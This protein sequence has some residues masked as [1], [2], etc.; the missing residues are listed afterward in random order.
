LNEDGGRRGSRRGSKM[1]AP[2]I[3]KLDSV[4]EYELDVAAFKA[5]K[6]R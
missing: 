6:E 4:E 1:N 2:G 3:I 5:I